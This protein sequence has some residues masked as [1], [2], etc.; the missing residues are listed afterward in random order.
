MTL[1]ELLMLHFMAQKEGIKFFIHSFLLRNEKK[2][3][4]CIIIIPM[5]IYNF[6]VATLNVTS[7]HLLLPSFLLFFPQLFTFLCKICF[8]FLLFSHGMSRMCVGRFVCVR[9]EAFDIITINKRNFMHI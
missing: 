5:L 2:E 9:P 3:F 7:V 4:L 8:S 6:T 1:E